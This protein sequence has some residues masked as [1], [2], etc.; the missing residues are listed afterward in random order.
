MV[1]ENFFEDDK[2]YIIKKF[3]TKAGW[4]EILILLPILS[5][6]ILDYGKA[7]YDYAFSL[8]AFTNNTILQQYF[9]Y[10]LF[11]FSVIII[12]L[13]ISFGIFKMF[14]NFLLKDKKVSSKSQK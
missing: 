6:V 1:D 10:L 9:G 7:I 14:E 3:Q 11:S 8:A 2:N 13:G 12:G 4:I 5:F